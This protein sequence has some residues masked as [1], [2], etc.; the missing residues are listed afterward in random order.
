MLPT[1]YRPNNINMAPTN[2]PIGDTDEPLID[3][4]VSQWVPGLALHNVALCCF[5]SERDGWYLPEETVTHRD[6]VATRLH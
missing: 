3:Q 4:F 2:L 5:I 1:V 6:T